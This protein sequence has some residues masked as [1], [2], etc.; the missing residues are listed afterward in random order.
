LARKP[1]AVAEPNP[2][3]DQ[4]R[5]V[6][7]ILA[8][9]GEPAEICC[10]IANGAITAHNK[11]LSCGILTQAAITANPP[12]HQLIAALERCKDG[13]AMTETRG[14]VALTSGPLRVSLPTVPGLQPSA[15]DAYR[16]A[17]PAA[18][19]NAIGQIAFLADED[20]EHIQS[21]S[22]CIDEGLV[23]TTNR[24]VI[25]QAYHGLNMPTMMLP[26]RFVGAVLKTGKT[27]VGMGH[28]ERSFTV[29]FEDGSW[30][31]TALMDAEPLP[32]SKVCAYAGSWR[33]MPEIWEALE[34]IMP[35]RGNTDAV[36]M[37]DKFIATETASY[38]CDGWTHICRINAD[39]LK[40]CKP[41]IEQ[42]AIDNGKFYFYKG[43]VRGVIALMQ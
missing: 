26:K 15:P 25:L 28:G 41:L 6:A 10:V 35:F 14:T 38:D 1:K 40:Q 42:F 34:T 2:L 30:L 20:A 4:L 33:A 36:N 16:E 32:Y 37:R 19:F 39:Y 17:L 43:N 5:F 27:I 31:R 29:F 3:L 21:A 24:N 8:K 18:L 13:Y 12:A 11:P 7:S 23:S 22:I 9:K